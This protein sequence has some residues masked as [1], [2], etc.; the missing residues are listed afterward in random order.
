MKMM[1]MLK[2]MTMKEMMLDCIYITHISFYVSVTV[3]SFF[4]NQNNSNEAPL[5]VARIS[6]SEREGE[7]QNAEI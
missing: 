4:E 2:V 6:G 7:R 5:S 3:L 1:M